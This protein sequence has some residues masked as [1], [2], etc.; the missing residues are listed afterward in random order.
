MSKAIHP[1]H[2]D[3]YALNVPGLEPTAN[4]G[5]EEEPLVHFSAS[6]DELRMENEDLR[7]QM[8]R[9]ESS[10]AQQQSEIRGWMSRIEAAIQ[11]NSN[12]SIRP[13]SVSPDVST[14]AQYYPGAAA[15]PGQPPS[16]NLHH[17][18][19]AY[20][21]QAPEHQQMYPTRQYVRPPQLPSQQPQRA[22]AD[23]RYHQPTTVHRQSSEMVAS[24][25]G[26]S[27]N[28]D[29]VYRGNGGST[30]ESQAAAAGQGHFSLQRTKPGMTQQQL[31]R[32][33]A[34]AQAQVHHS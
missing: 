24:H 20:P 26:A 12:M 21:P 18:Y 19:P 29:G 13:R 1:M 5:H 6:I 33:Q 3:G 25:G 11:G 23:S 15:V 17:R 8:Q 34:Q 27:H 10:L 31:A 16:T 30:A 32:A 9:I 14:S 2:Q 7:Y 22:Y 4:A 28:E